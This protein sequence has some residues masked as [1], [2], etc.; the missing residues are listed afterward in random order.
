MNDPAAAISV[1]DVDPDLGAGVPPGELAEATRAAT[2]ACVHVDP[3]EWRAPD[4]AEPGH[5][6]LIVL[7]GLLTRTVTL[8]GRASVELLGHGDLLRPWIPLGTDS[9]LEG[10]VRWDVIE[11]AQLAVLDVSFARQ[12]SRWPEITSALMDRQMMRARWLAFTLAVSHVR[13]VDDR[14][15]L[16]FWHLADRWGRMTGDGIVVPLHLSHQSLAL[17]VGAQRPSVTTAL[18]NLRRGGTIERRAD[19]SWTLR[20]D[21]P[22]VMGV[23]GSPPESASG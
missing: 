3:G 5:L 9:S 2:A 13:R 18:G 12:I 20:G 11:R 8:A 21:P 1:L 22:S 14:L 16:L 17:L 10:N 23:G 15:R 19:G 4:A 7:E 6:G